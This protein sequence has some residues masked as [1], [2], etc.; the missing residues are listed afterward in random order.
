MEKCVTFLHEKEIFY[1][2]PARTF[3]YAS[4]HI[5]KCDSEAEAG[6]CS[7]PGGPKKQ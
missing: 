5:S 7:H 1:S 4:F 3:A 2:G 6:E